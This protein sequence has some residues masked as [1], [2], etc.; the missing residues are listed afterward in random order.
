MQHVGGTAQLHSSPAYSLPD[1]HNMQTQCVQDPPKKFLGCLEP[2]PATAT[3]Q[4]AADP[5]TDL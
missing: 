3:L 4:G 1:F 5:Q 2:L